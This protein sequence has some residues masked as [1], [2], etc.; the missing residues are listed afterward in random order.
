MTSLFKCDRNSLQR[1]VQ[2]GTQWIKW[3]GEGGGKE[4]QGKRGVGYR[5]MEGEKKGE[6]KSMYTHDGREYMFNK[7]ILMIN[8]YKDIW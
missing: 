4:R 8:C 2:M 3:A 6:V 5:E 1:K 7:V